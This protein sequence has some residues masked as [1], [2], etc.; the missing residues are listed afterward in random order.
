MMDESLFQQ[1]GWFTLEPGRQAAPGPER[2][3]PPSVRS[4]A[5]EPRAERPPALPGEI[6][7]MARAAKGEPAA[8]AWLVKRVM[9]RVRKIA[10][11]FLKSAAD[12]DDAAQL[13]LLAILG[14]A[15]TYRGE[16]PVEAWAKRIAV[17]TTLRFIHKERRTASSPTDEEA[18]EEPMHEPEP[19]TAEGLPREVRDYLELLPE[20]QKEA[21]ILHHALEHSIDEI[22]EMTDVSPD[23]VKG[24]LRL[25]TAALKKQVR[26]DLAIGRRRKQ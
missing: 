18:A 3:T 13:S 20:A 16:A 6:E 22:A 15:H 23:T 12:S 21:I 11:A 10:R 24:R 7:L 5:L 9:P 19:L 14:S 2:M 17:R 4:T 1:S 25:G 26:Q 8:Q